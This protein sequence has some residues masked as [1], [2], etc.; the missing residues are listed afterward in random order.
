M[1]ETINN[2]PTK[3]QAPHKTFKFIRSEP[4]ESLGVEVAEYEHLVTGA[5]HF[6]IA[7]D[8]TENVFLVALRTIPTD[9]T[10][11]AHILEHTALCGSKRYPVRDPF[12]MMIR[13]SLNTFM[14]AF[15]SSD[16]TAYPF[17]SQ[18]RKDFNNLLDVYL[19]AVFFSRLD[20][21]DFAQEGHR[22]EFA[23]PG[24]TDSELTF[25]GVVFNEMKGA[26]SSPVS[27]LWQTLSKH[28]FPTTTYHHNS[29]GEPECIPDL[30]YEELKAFYQVHYHPSNAV[31]MTFGDIPAA[32]HQRCFEDRALNQFQRLDQ[33][34]TVEDEKR[35]HAPI[36]IEEAYALDETDTDNKTHVVLG[37][38]LGH[39]INLDEQLEA[40]LL[41]RV[42]LDN[43]ASPLRHALET[44]E[45]GTAPSPLCGLE[46]S[47]R[48]M[49]FMCGL[50]GCNPD[51]ASQVEELV[52]SVLEQV[53]EEGVPQSQV[54]AVLHQL[55]LSQREI[56][57]DSYPYGLQLILEALSTA[58][59]RGDPIALLNIDPALEKLREQIKQPD[60]I[61]QL[62][63]RYLLDNSHRARLTLR[64]DAELAGRR[65]AAEAL[66]LE[67]IKSSL[68]E[69][70]KQ[71]IVDQASA[72]QV[73]QT[74]EDDESILPKV[75]LADIPE[76][77]A[78]PEGQAIASDR[79]RIDYY[80]Q[81]TNGLVYQQIIVPLP[82]LTE[83][84][85]LLLPY[86]STCVTELG[87][88][89]LS[90]QQVQ[91]LQSSISGGV[92][93]FSSVRGDID[94][95]QKVKGY[96]TVSG[97]ALVRN[98]AP[99]TDLLHETY[100][101]VRFD[102][103][104]RIRELISMQ[105]ARREQSITGNGHGLA[106]AAAVSG[107]SPVASL[108]HRHN[109]LQGI[110]FIKALDE[111]LKDNQA[112]KA[113]ADELE[114]LYKLIIQ[115]ERRFLCVAE[116]ER[117]SALQ[118]S[119][120]KYWPETEKLTSFKDFSLPETRSGVKQIWGTSTQVN[121]CAKAFPTVPV[122]HEDSAALTVLG[123]FLRN[124]YL[125]R[126]IREQGGAYGGG[127]GQDSASAAFRFFS[128]RDPRLDET[129]ADFDASI[130]W[131]L[132]EEHSA[133]RLEEAILG[134]VGSIDKPGSP[135]GEAKQAFHNGLYGRTPEQRRRFRSQ[136]LKVSLDDLK[137]VTNT[138][139][140][141]N[142]SSVAVITDNQTAQQYADKGF[143]VISL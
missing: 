26:M 47:N 8:N 100:N 28:L 9:S 55:E 94:N 4:I 77:F 61:Q 82:E 138:Y 108:S 22:L 105:R 56:G 96:F 104:E 41:S 120:S 119:I 83:R 101:H 64:P 111:E 69:D 75:G 37:W 139:L 24:N 70:Q 140:K 85:Q 43:S 130:D 129:L 31:F 51:Q 133:N 53:A 68:D 30:S 141:D 34:V 7:A 78:I 121:F 45:I 10:G 48:E 5:K 125:H 123:G 54:E 74:Q 76:S 19:D 46:D 143:E 15:T 14:N 95:E 102:E 49:S 57:G 90:Y 127:A 118:E 88:G 86:L 87:Y 99:L 128:Y 62:V 80:S 81:G 124:G 38:L 39:S 84:Q 50:E 18:N 17:A 113:F 112:L 40:D 73:R 115:G 52:L 89:Q 63:K 21:L 71:A 35:Y 110:A 66:R 93:A 6:H 116:E 2:T 29:G 122:E 114:A 58:I 136:V 92:S 20:P 91:A 67:R 109:G 60:Y 11:V 107:Y 103:L 42:L 98:V 131:M 137:R 142:P 72:L 1:N 126:V 117:Q 23:E 132:A 3:L 33:I 59:H 16:W 106:M 25:K 79:G 134:V 44:A 12:F 27:T 13:R 65:D 97:K 32:E 135:A 36:R